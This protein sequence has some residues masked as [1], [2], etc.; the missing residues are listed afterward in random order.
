MSVHE[1]LN[2]N[3]FRGQVSDGAWLN[4][5]TREIWIQFEG[6]ILLLR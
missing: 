4:Y 3:V 6:L 5:V 1:L 2:E